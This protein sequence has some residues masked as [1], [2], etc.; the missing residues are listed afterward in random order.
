MLLQIGEGKVVKDLVPHGKAE[1][2]KKLPQTIDQAEVIGGSIDMEPFR[3]GLLA[4]R[5]NNFFKRHREERR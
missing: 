2:G 4:G 3:T 5:G 1:T